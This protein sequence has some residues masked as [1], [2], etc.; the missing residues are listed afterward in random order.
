M[1]IYSDVDKFDPER[2]PG[3]TMMGD[4]QSRLRNNSDCGSKSQDYFCDVVLAVVADFLFNIY[5]FSYIH[6]YNEKR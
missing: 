1:G 4:V 6:S 5:I 3:A 2:K